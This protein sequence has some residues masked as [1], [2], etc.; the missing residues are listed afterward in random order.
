[1]VRERGE[2]VTPFP[3]FSQIRALRSQIDEVES[4]GEVDH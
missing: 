3:S 4:L 2:V 1:M